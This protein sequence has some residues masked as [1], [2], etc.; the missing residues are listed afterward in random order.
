MAAANTEEQSV[1]N[2]VLEISERRPPHGFWFLSTLLNWTSSSTVFLSALEERIL[3]FLKTPYEVFFVDIG[4]TVGSQDKIWTIA[5]NTK[6]PEVPLVLLH[7]LGAGIALWVL[8][9]DAFSEHRPVYAMDI[10]GFG[11]SSRPQF[12]R[13]AL[14]CEMQF[15][16]SVEKWRREMKIDQMILL[17]HSMGGYIASSYAIS[18]P[19]NV[20]HLVLA[21]P[22]GFPEK[23]TVSVCRRQFPLWIRAIAYAITPFNPLFIL[24]AAGPFG[25]WLI[26]KIRPD[27]V[28]KF[29]VVVEDK[30]IF[31]HY[32]HQCN[33][34]RPS[35]ESAFH[36]MIEFLGCAKFPMCNRITAV[37]DDIPITFIYGSSS[38]IDSVSGEKVKSE[39]RNSFVEIK[40]ID[41]AGHHVYADKP[42]VFNSYVNEIC[43]I[44]KLREHL[45]SQ[46][47]QQQRSSDDS[48]HTGMVENRNNN[49]LYGN[50]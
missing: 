45:T 31:P 4:A 18:H 28:R 47:N 41:G 21:D 24:R 29:S 16:N 6:S 1:S 14:T 49:E 19:D 3:S 10:L 42:E 23:S 27:I 11:R 33:A 40:N 44:Y 7:G 38:W 9:L 5:L 25:K 12:S 8:N 26:Q 34:Q 46:D 17:G 43:N 30:D 13:D 35:G 20:K 37:R 32:I 22:W 15:V 2:D 39:R 50:A 48:L 36:S